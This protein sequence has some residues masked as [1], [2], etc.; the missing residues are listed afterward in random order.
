MELRQSFRIN[1]I[2]HSEFFPQQCMFCQWVIF[3]DLTLYYWDFSP[4]TATYFKEFGRSCFLKLHS[5][6]P[7]HTFFCNVTLTFSNQEMTFV[8]SSIESEP[9]VWLL[10]PIEPRG[11]AILELLRPSASNAWQ[12]SPLC[13]GGSMSTCEKLWNHHT[14]R[15]PKLVTLEAVWREKEMPN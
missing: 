7:F 14:V 11:I 10:W 1:S 3:I 4:S 8:S 6:F 12:C 15:K 2:L 13:S 9:P 5:K